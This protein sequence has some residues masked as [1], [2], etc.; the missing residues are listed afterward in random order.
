MRFA[1]SV[2]LAIGTT[3]QAQDIVVTG[4]P[5]PATRGDASFARVTIDSARLNGTA[6]GRLE[7]ALRDVA[8]VQ[9]FR[10]SDAR[11]AN[12]TSQGVTLRGLGGTAASRALVLLDGVPQGD[13][14]GGFITWPLYDGGRI[15]Q[16]TVTRG[17]GSGFA[18][19]GALAG[20]IDLD[21]VTVAQAPD[22]AL[23][24]ALG[25]RASVTGT[26]LAAGQLGAGFG[27]VSAS[28][29]RGD[30][31]VPIVASQRGPVD[32]AARYR[33]VAIAARG[34][35]PIAALAELQ[36]NIALFDDIRSRGTAFS[37]NVTRGADASLRLV[38]S[39]ATPFAV[40]GYVQLRRF[41]SRFAS[42]DAARVT[43]TP[44]LDQ[45][46]T[47]ATGLGL[48]A[49]LRPFAALR[50]GGD[51]RQVSGQTQ[52]RFAY[53]G[54][55]AT[56]LREAGGAATTAGIF[57]DADHRF[58]KLDLTGG[59]RIDRWRIA[60]GRLIERSIGSGATLT[61]NLFAA[62]SNWQATGRIG[63][64]LAV[65]PVLAL[66]AAAYAGWRL[67]TLNELY[68]PFRVG[69]D[70]TAANAMLA[71]ETS[72]GVEIGASLTRGPLS[73]TA[74]AFANRLD[75]AIA[76]VSLGRGP[77]NFAGV[78]F[79][80][81]VY[82][83]RLNIAAISSR[84]VEV[85]LH[86][87][88]GAWAVQASLALTDARVRADGIASGLD[89]LRP[90]AVAPLQASMSVSWQA[91]TLTA[92]YTSAQFDDDQNQRRLAPALTLDAVAGV[93]LTKLLSVVLRAENLFDKTVAAAFS[94]NGAIERA[95]PRT[96]WLGLHWRR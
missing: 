58:G 47:P 45:Y 55:V 8:G 1:L 10:R 57:A 52:E 59:A 29:A 69:A 36:A 33:Q 83:Q 4:R 27:L 31:F 25:S 7:D 79:V 49:E 37:D 90:A 14:F 67:P 84:G 38:G 86:W 18:G 71:P 88:D 43:V 13:P 63:A 80:A 35:V 54:G 64:S 53:V 89:G 68:R 50:V 21:S 96:L 44:T 42:V 56:R 20:T 48:R 22:L 72:R 23:S 87:A 30:G 9:Q 11:S 15:G 6:S 46:D 17:G 26:A 3:A 12:P 60:P 95:S 51:L 62:R 65:A 24:A 66:R 28:V 16:V 85:D 93:P 74:T 81:G 77:G 76:N 19:P 34:V 61:D 73:V 78:G 75:D 5:P 41:A 39:G 91:L 32:T 40:L 70:A 94:A 92:R 2:L 82:R